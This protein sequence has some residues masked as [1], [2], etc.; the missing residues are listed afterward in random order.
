MSEPLLVD[1]IQ[2]R[3]HN[4]FQ[5]ADGQASAVRR[6]VTGVSTHGEPQIVSDG[7]PPRS[8]AHVAVPG[9][10]NSVVWATA[11][12]PESGYRDLTPDLV[13][14]VPGAGET[15]ALLVTFPPDTVFADPLFDGPKAAREQMEITPGLAEL[16][17][18]D[19]PGFHTTPTVDYGVVVS[20]EVV[21]DLG[22]ATTVLRQGDIIVQNG[23][24]HAWRNH[25][26][27]PATVF[28]V[29]IGR[30]PA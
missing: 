28:F 4:H 9:M 7:P 27:Q 17:E 19:N 1:A 26:D 3:D 13:T 30:K 6:V 29:L 16:F 8:R 2:G 24:R 23:T 21:L 5:G 22:S 14:L 15:V 18:Q 10:V 20:G 12:P 25:T 11:A